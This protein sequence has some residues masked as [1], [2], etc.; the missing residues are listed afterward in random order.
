MALKTFNVDEEVYKEFSQHCKKQ[1]I[2]MSKKVENFIRKE[3]AKI[4]SPLQTK[5]TIRLR[6]ENVPK[7]TH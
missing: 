7:Y 5:E 1:G 3:V 4:S 2:S 6:T